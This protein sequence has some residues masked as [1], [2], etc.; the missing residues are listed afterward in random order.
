MQNYLFASD[1]DNTLLFSYKHAQESDLC[2]EELHG[3]KQGYMTLGTAERLKSIYET[4]LFVPVTSRSMEQYRRIQFPTDCV[5]KYALTT[6]GAILLVDGKIDDVWYQTHWKQVDPWREELLRLYKSLKQ[7]D[8]L[9]SYRIVDEM[10]L[11]AACSCAEEAVHLQKIYEKDTDLHVAASGRKVYFFPP[12]IN[13]GSAV[14]DL[15]A[16]LCPDVTICAG[17]SSIDVP[18]LEV[19]DAAIAPASLSVH[20]EHLYRG[21]EGRA[22]P[23]FV[24]KTALE[25]VRMGQ[26]L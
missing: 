9:T 1:L 11:F 18:M 12:P 20:A 24:T 13:K 23:D 21:P 8:F 19:A 2:V 26:Q 3:N 10:Y 14:R 6:N 16:I 15:Q 22:F 25:L 17:D 4:M 7:F 5:P